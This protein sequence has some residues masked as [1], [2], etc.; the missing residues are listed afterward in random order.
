VGHVF[1]GRFRSILCDKQAYLL[2]LLRYIHLNPVR[3]GM[4]KQPHQWP[5]SSLSTFLGREKNEW[6]YQKDVLELFGRWPRRKLLAFLTQAPDLKGVEIYSAEDFPILGAESFTQIAV[7]SSEPR[8]RRKRVYTGPK[9][10]LPRIAEILCEKE[11]FPLR[12]LRV[13]RKGNRKLTELREKVVYAATRIMFHK[14]AEVARFLEVSACTLSFCLR[15]FSKK[16]EETLN[17][18]LMEN[19]KI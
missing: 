13:S 3:A 7:A 10:S 16:L 12:Q 19:S 8:R 1:Q 5:W 11:R 6:L 14:P 4:V 17:H 2:E 9:L 15:R 18:W